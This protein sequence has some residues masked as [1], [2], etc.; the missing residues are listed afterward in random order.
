MPFKGFV[1]IA[2][3]NTASIA[4]IGLRGHWN[5]RND[6][7]IATIPPVDESYSLPPK[8]VFPQLVD[9]GGYTTQL[10]SIW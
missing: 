2:S 4:V 7:L 1:R 5:E 10:I 6:F 8:V 9:G 3:S